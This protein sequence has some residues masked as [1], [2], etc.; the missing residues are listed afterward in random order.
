MLEITQQNQFFLF[1]FE[2]HKTDQT[3]FFD[4]LYWQQQERILGQAQGRGTTWF[5]KSS[6]LF[7]VNCALRHYYRGGLF[8][9]IIKD[10][11]HFS[12]LTKTRS[13]AEFHL[14][15]KLHQ[16]GIAVP[17]PIGAKVEKLTFGYY[18]AD[19]LSEKIENSQ[20]LTA[21]LQ[22]QQL[23]DSTWQNIGQLIRQLHDLQICHTD[24]NAH[25]I[26][27]QQVEQDT[28]KC[29]LIDFDKCAEK[30]GDDWK[31]KN[32]QR[33]HR[34]FQKEVKRMNIHF[35]QQNW[36]QLLQGYQQS[37]SLNK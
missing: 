28:T 18:R 33:L 16:A 11:Y 12:S 35:T 36:Q 3:Q 25:N 31:V 8:G 6:D 20:D 9:K 10:C 22:Q 1:N 14:L 7:G 23:S 34:S 5:I 37:T 19:I 32:L 26:L 4:P 2:Q 13:F 21:L 15:N 30:I 24:L 17:K 29:W 27:I